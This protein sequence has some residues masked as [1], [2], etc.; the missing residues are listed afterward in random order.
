MRRAWREAVAV[1]WI[2]GSALR[3]RALGHLAAGLAVA[4][5]ATVLVGVFAVAEGFRRSVAL[6]AD[7]DTVLVLRAG[8]GSE[9][10]SVVPSETARIIESLPGWRRDADGP[11][12]SSELV[13]VVPV[14]QVPPHLERSLTLRG[15]GRGTA[16]V[17]DRFR[18][19]AGR[20]LRPGRPELLVGEA[21]Q[22]RFTGLAVGDAVPV[23]GEPWRIVGVFRTGGRE[24]S[25]LWGDAR[26]LQ[27]LFR[28][29]D[30]VQ[31]VY[32]KVADAAALDGVRERLRDDPRTPVDAH[33]QRDFYAR[34][35]DPVTRLLHGL[36]F[37]LYAMMGGVAGFAALDAMYASVHS[38][39]GELAT[40]RAFGL[41][42]CALGAALLAEA[43]A[44]G[45][46]GGAVGGLAVLGLAD[47]VGAATF[48]F[49]AL[50]QVVFALEVTPEALVRGIALAAA[51]CG[52][53]A[54]AP[55]WS[56]L[57]AVPARWL[58]G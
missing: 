54:L 24:D 43:L 31:A 32:A 33:R 12:V 46:V 20:P 53:G 34:Q 41:T 42:R 39:R 29:G 4:G 2:A 25:E 57:R 9:L 38:R 18:L 55:A 21:A 15:V 40:L 51:L 14:P 37:F 13:L 19:V 3:T 44:V 50:S 35:A 30:T 11:R 48:D 47:G 45:L 27:S 23:A 17:R 16:R 10:L 8:A 56:A 22:R 1:V 36:A 52:I 49:R 28:R 5:V 26:L 58:R 6:G 7:D